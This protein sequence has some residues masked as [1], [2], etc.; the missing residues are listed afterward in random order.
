MLGVS[1]SGS[2]NNACRGRT[3]RDC[4]Q[5]AQC[6]AALFDAVCKGNEYRREGTVSFRPKAK[7]RQLTSAW[8]NSINILQ[9]YLS[10]LS[11]GF[12]DDVM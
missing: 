8:L 1:L 3:H 5:E 7:V 10:C 2:D 6:E 12:E 4:N 9:S 11:Q